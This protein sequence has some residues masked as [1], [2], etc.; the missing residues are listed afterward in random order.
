MNKNEKV[1]Q[2]YSLDHFEAA[3]GAFAT[4]NGVKDK[5]PECLC[6]KR[7]WYKDCWYLN[8]SIRPLG[9]N[10]NDEIDRQIKA[11]LDESPRR[12]RHIERIL[13]AARSSAKSRKEANGTNGSKQISLPEAGDDG[14]R[15]GLES[16]GT[17][18]VAS[19]SAMAVNALKDNWI[20]DSGS[21]VHI[22]NDRNALFDVRTPG[23][24]T[25][26]VAGTGRC[27]AGAIGSVIIKVNTPVGMKTMTIT[28]V[29]YVPGF[30][31]NIVSLSR[32][33]SKGVHFSTETSQLTRNGKVI[34]KIE[35]VAGHWIVSV[36][37]QPKRATFA[38]AASAQGARSEGQEMVAQAHP[39]AFALE[40]AQQDHDLSALWHARM[41]HPG[42]QALARLPGAVVGIRPFAINHAICE[43]CRL[44]KATQLISRS[45]DREYPEEH[46]FHRVSCDLLELDEGY[47]GDQFAVH[48][49]CFKTSFNCVFTQPQRV[50]LVGV[51]ETFIKHVELQFNQRVRI[52]RIDNDTA[53]GQTFD[54][55]ARQ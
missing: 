53:L 32:L 34:A 6:G 48:F 24:T 37:N 43:A 17:F 29:I 13:K 49:Q 18:A 11:K 16:V 39:A 1:L 50:G 31:T 25:E 46:P 26:I 41:A 35:P 20:L 33:N 40:K 28:D 27:I 12:K 7:H 10:P 51:I 47:N 9:W 5:T 44:S 52:L 23:A 42:P 3:S 4:L 19:Y 30:M 2:T 8:A 22:T 38:V 36:D 45:S 21:N 54:N 55:F 14:E 15:S